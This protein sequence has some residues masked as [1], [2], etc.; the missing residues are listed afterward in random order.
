MTKSVYSVHEAKT[1]LSRLLQ[2]VAA[3]DEVLI[4]RRGAVVARLVA[5][6]AAM[7]RRFGLDEGL[8][9]VPDDFNAPLPGELL[10]A[11]ER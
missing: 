8:F 7:P 6:R 11:F 2:Q 9:V 4:S 5:E 1:H 3:G 10:D